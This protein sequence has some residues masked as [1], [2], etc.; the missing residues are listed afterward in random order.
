MDSR[1]SHVYLRSL[2]TR[3]PRARKKGKGVILDEF[4]KNERLQSGLCDSP[5][6]RRLQLCGGTDSSP[7]SPLL[8]GRGCC[9]AR[10]YLRSLG[11]DVF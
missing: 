1:P 9:G 10:T 5:P 11:W 4:T 7:A 3:Y 2:Q 8:H 6:P